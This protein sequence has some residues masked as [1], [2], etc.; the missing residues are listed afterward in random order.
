[1]KAIIISAGSATRLKPHTKKLPKGLLNINGKTIMDRQIKI[2][3]NNGINDII[4]ITGPHKEQFRYDEVR[5]VNDLE[6]EKHDV[7]FSLMV[8]KNEIKGEVITIY[9]DVLF[10][11]DIL[12]QIIK[13]KVDIGIAIEMN[14]EKNYENRTEHPKSEADNVIIENNTIV[15]IKKNIPKI[16]ENQKDGEFIGIMKFS[17]KGSERFVMEFNRV[18]KIKPQPFHDASIFEKSYLTD[19]IQELIDQNIPVEPIFINGDWCE[20]D[21]FQD[22][23]NARKKYN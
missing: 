23:E 7:L 13:S 1:M 2:L 3:R 12:Q 8:A 5:F 22:L 9:S 11:E 20:I 18:E 14:W 15:E 21:T 19:M 17:E 16:L 10:D 4:I 6:Y